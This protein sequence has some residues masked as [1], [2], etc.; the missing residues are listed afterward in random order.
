MIRI[1]LI[2]ALLCIVPCFA[3][4]YTPELIKDELVE[5]TLQNVSGDYPV[6][7]LKPDFTNINFI[8]LRLKFYEEISTKDKTH[9]EGQIIKFEIVQDVYDGK[10]K[11]LPRG[12]VGHA[13]IETI[14]RRGFMGVPADIII[15][16][17]EV[18]EL[19][20][21]RFQNDVVKSGRNLMGL[22]TALKYSIGTF[23]P[24][25]GYFF[26]LIKGGNANI[27]PDEVFEV[28]YAY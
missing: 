12:T 2:A 27:K 16:N 23:L 6:V 9:T 24:G 5:T 7:N 21:L 28:K 17:F 14:S 4:E 8:P 10:K 1:F 20:T 19:D 3:A 11:I 25:T 18:G 15:S 26:M 13:R 22:A